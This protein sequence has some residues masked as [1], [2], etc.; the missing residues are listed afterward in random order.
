MLA[1]IGSLSQ[2][3]GHIS[4]SRVRPLRRHRVFMAAFLQPFSCRRE[5]AS[6]PER[7][8]ENKKEGK[9]EK[10]EGN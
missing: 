9:G 8:R 2:N 7:V 4:P 3:L 6:A 1:N 5:S 10:K